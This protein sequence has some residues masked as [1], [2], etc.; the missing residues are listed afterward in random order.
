MTKKTPPRPR[1]LINQ[2]I[3]KIN[4]DADRKQRK[5]AK[6]AGYT[7]GNT[8]AVGNA[9]KTTT[10]TVEIGMEL[11]S[12][13][14]SGRSLRDVCKDPD[15]PSQKTV[16]EWQKRHPVFR[17][18]FMQAEIEQMFAWAHDIVGIAEDAFAGRILKVALDD[19]DL[20]KTEEDG[21]VVFRFDKRHVDE[22]KLLI[23]TKQW[24]MER[25]D[26]ERY[27]LRQFLDVKQHYYESTDEELIHGFVSAC[28][29]AGIM[30]AEDLKEWFDQVPVEETKH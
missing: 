14:S 18:Q 24:L 15:M 23:Q 12:R 25:L 29:R 6:E 4:K 2:S 8:A 5:L 19:P 11:T 7:K 20:K 27:G 28:R 3:E 22:A 1:K 16:W 26:S 10:Y 17:N 21:Y 9:G 30:Q 13:I